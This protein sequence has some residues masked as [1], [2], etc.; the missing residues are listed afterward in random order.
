MTRLRQRRE[1]GD[2]TVEGQFD[3]T[4][5]QLDIDRHL[6]VLIDLA[7]ARNPI[8]MLVA[9]V[10]MFDNVLELESGTQ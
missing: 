10:V 4:G 6:T 1:L 3:R 9:G 7:N 5:V 2:G 8:K